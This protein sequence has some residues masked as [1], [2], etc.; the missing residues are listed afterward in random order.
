MIEEDILEEELGE[1]PYP[2][3]SPVE[4]A[5]AKLID[6]LIAGFLFELAP[7]TGP[8]AGVAYI[9]ICDG[10]SGGQSAGKRLAGLATISLLRDGSGCDFL[11]SIKRNF[12]FAVPFALFVVV[13]WIP[14]VG[15]LLVVLAGSVVVLLELYTL[16]EDERGLRIG[17][18]LAVTMVVKKDHSQT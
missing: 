16:Y 4:R 8:I 11:E 12:L 15:G 14:Y 10:F 17:D 9:L 3:V 1:L 6:F 5:V 18:R 2:K 7:V 13:G